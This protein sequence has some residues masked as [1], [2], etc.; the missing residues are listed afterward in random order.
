MTTA[1]LTDVTNEADHVDFLLYELDRAMIVDD[2]ILPTDVVRLG[3]IVRYRA[4][5]AG[6]RTIK[7][8][9][10]REVDDA[11]SYRLSVTSMH[12]A[13]LLGLRPKQS[14]SWIGATGQADSVEV[15]Q[16]AN[17]RVRA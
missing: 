13:A 17:S 4:A 2:D 3:S 8:V 16:V 11:R 6:E 14:L 1:A 10:P 9:L 5:S 7:L 12:G 15:L